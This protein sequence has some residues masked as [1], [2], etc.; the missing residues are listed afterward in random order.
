[1][2]YRL[3]YD[4]IVYVVDPP[5]RRYENKPIPHVFDLNTLCLFLGKHE[6]N[7]TLLIADT[8]VPWAAEWLVFYEVW[9]A[10]GEWLGGGVHPRAGSTSRSARR[11]RS[12]AGATE[13][14]RLRSAM[15]QIYGDAGVNERMGN[16]DV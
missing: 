15:R 11:S 12:A 5:L 14:D 16:A 7:P 10:I 13:D 1:M 3:T 9:L 2:A 6:W 8:I 4:P